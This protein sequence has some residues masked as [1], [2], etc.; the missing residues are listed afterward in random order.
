[1]ETMYDDNLTL[2]ARSTRSPQGRYAKECTWPLL[3]RRLRA[4]VSR[5][6]WGWLRRAAASVAVILM[7]V[8]G[9]AMYTTLIRPAVLKK[10]VPMEVTAPQ[11]QGLRSTMTFQ[12]VPLQQIVDELNQTFASDIRIADEAL[13]DLHITATF[14]ADETLESILAV[15]QRVADLQ[16]EHQGQTI[17]IK[18]GGAADEG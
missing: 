14:Q 15:L 6:R 10:E 12:Q 8:L 2:L 9:W 3:E 13:R 17:I 18:K 11:T 5:E 16:I 4:Q 7:V 1:M